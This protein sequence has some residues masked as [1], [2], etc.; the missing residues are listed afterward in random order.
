MFPNLEIV[1]P[2]RSEDSISESLRELTRQ[3]CL[4]TDDDGSGGLGG[5]Y[6]YGCNFE[7]NIFMM[8]RY[9]WCERDDC[10]WCTEESPNFLFKSTGAEII[11][12]KYIGRDQH[13][14][15][16][17]LPED[18]LK[19]CLS[20][21]WE[22]DDC[23][24]E[25]SKTY[26]DDENERDL[27]T[28]CFSPFDKNAIIKIYLNYF[29][30]LYVVKTWDADTFFNTFFDEDMNESEYN[31]VQKLRK[32]YPQMDK[33]INEMALE[34]NKDMIEWHQKRIEIIKDCKNDKPRN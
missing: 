8:H 16:G 22:E 24:I 29:N 14:S 25:F 19:Q 15:L 5:E 13:L 32:K 9:C 3:I 34:Y 31:K 4:K 33:K 12:Y 27:I 28:L 2:E 11:W 20:S 30:P 6:G 23:W 7:N 21:I 17:K 26:N 1:L 10:P 18:W